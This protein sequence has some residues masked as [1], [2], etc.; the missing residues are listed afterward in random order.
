MAQVCDSDSEFGETDFEGVLPK[1]VQIHG[2]LGDSH[3][4]LFGQ[5]CLKPGMTKSTY[6]TGS[7]IMMNIGE[8]PVLSTHGVVTSLAWSM[9]GKSELCAGRQL[10]LYGRGHHLGLRMI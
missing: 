9:G 8:K 5:G 3:G 1:K 10:E 7:S 6:G 4:S 2:V